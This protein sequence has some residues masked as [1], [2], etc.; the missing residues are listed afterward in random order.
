MSRVSRVHEESPI[1]S[2]LPSADAAPGR[3]AARL[4]GGGVVS[5]QQGFKSRHDPSVAVSRPTRVFR[6]GN[7]APLRGLREG[8]KREPW[9]RVH[10]SPSPRA[11]M[12]RSTWV[13]PPWMV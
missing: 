4:A 1:N 9:R 12:P 10:R 7:I 5:H 13:V 8:R 3:G 2:P 11:T 6:A